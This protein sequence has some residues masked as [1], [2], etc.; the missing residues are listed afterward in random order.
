MDSKAVLARFEAER[1]ALAMMDHPNIAKVLDA[2]TTA[3][4]RPYFVMELVKGMPITE[5]CDDRKLT[6]RQ[7]LEL[8]VPV[9][10]AIQHAHQKGDHPPRHQAVERAGRAVRRQAGAEGDRLRRGEGDRPAADRQDARHRLRRRWSARRSTC[11]P[12]QADA[13]QPGHRHAQRRL[14][15]RRAAVRTARPAATP[16]DRKALEQGGAAGDAADRP[17]GGAAA[18]EHQAEHAPTTLPSIAANRGTEP[19]KLTELL[20]GELDWIV[21]KALEKDRTRRYETANGFAADVQRYLAGEPVQAVPPSLGVPAA[22]GVPAEPGGGGW[23]RR[24]CA[25]T[26]GGGDGGVLAVQAKRAEA[27]AVGDAPPPAPPNGGRRRRSCRP[28]H[29]RLLLQGVSRAKPTRAVRRPG[30]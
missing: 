3:D 17:R 12:E 15:A 30:P 2:G 18:A 6:P 22:E 9:C 10:Q 5:Y 19:A 28:R 8:F 16:F 29:Q 27:E 23:R 7:R 26:R 14:L 11:R 24:S 21:M 13:Q 1:Q 25:G 20:R 4:G